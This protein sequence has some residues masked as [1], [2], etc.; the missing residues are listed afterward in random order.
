MQEDSIILLKNN[1]LVCV[2]KQFLS[3]IL[4]KVAKILKCVMLDAETGR[5]STNV[6]NNLD[7]HCVIV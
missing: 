5:F 1:N 4:Q 3:R 2:H 6:C 7:W